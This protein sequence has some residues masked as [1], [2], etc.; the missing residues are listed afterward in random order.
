M[1]IWSALILLMLAPLCRSETPAI[2]E[3]TVVAYAKAI[4][5]EK[6]DPA[7]PSQRL[8]EWLRLGPPRLENVRWRRSSCDLKPDYPEPPDGYPLC[9]KFVYRRSRVSG[10]AIVKIGTMRKGIFGPPR[11]EYAVLSVRSGKELR[12]DEAETLRDFPQVI[13]RLLA[14]TR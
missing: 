10:W 6:L 7:L 8:E 13:S 1:R 9:V 3:A 14:E 4:D 12:Y 5:V 11:F 2:D